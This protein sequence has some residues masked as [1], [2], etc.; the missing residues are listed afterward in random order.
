MSNGVTTVR[1]ISKI[2][3]FPAST[4]QYD[5]KGLDELADMR[6][7]YYLDVCFKREVMN[8]LNG[9]DTNIRKLSGLTVVVVDVITQGG[10]L[11]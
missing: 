9:L 4:L 5:I 10:V 7:S 2:L 6:M 8:T 1:G 11:N 3:D